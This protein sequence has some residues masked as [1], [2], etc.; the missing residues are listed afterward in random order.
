M[1]YYVS[2]ANYINYLNWLKIA[3]QYDDQVMDSEKGG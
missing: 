3:A 1:Y 2:Y